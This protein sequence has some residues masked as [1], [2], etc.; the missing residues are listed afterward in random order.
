MSSVS[1]HVKPPNV[2]QFKVTGLGYLT[3][4]NYLVGSILPAER[5]VILP[6]W[7]SCKELWGRNILIMHM[8]E[9]IEK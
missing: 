8:N 4:T 3:Q 7:E 6:K 9:D 5:E 1:E 2:S